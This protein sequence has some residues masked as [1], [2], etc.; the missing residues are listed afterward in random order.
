MGER[1]S[2]IMGAG[3]FGGTY[4]GRRGETWGTLGGP[5]WSACKHRLAASGPE[6]FCILDKRFHCQLGA[7]NEDLI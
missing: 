4:R 6:Y 7:H 2:R 1:L 3:A 5:W